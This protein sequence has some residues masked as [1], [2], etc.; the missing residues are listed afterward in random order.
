MKARS[1]VLVALMLASVACGRRELE[2]GGV[3]VRRT[4][5]PQVAIPAATGD[6]TLFDPANRT[7][8]AAIDVV[9]TMT[10]VRSTCDEGAAQIVSTATFDVVATRR[11]A[12]EARTVVLPYYDVAMQAGEKVVAKRIGQVAVTFAAGS[13]RG[14]GR[15]QGTISVSRAATVLP[16]NVRAELT[17]ERKVGDANAAIDPL[18]DPAIRAAV[19]RATFEHLIGFQL[20]QAQLQYNATR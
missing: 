1:L 12:G 17:R 2:S 3:Y 20:T 14:A 16:E 10:N 11:D 19:A 13:Q 8:S 7:D 9:A 4:V 15:A 6:V 18:S 5:C